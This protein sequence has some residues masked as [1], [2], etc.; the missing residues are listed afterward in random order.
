MPGLKQLQKF[1][2]DVAD[3]GQELSKRAAR[4]EP[5]ATYPLPQGI[6]EA[7]DSDDFISGL[8][9]Q[10]SSG[11]AEAEN[12]DMQA[13]EQDDFVP[14]DN[15][16]PSVSADDFSEPSLNDV[17][18]ADA[19]PPQDAFS[20]D[21]SL[22]FSLPDLDFSDDAVSD[23]SDLFNT[24]TDF[25]TDSNPLDIDSVLADENA[26]QDSIDNSESGESAERDSDVPP[27]TDFQAQSDFPADEASELPPADLQMPDDF[28]LPDDF[29]DNFSAD[30][31]TEPFAPEVP[32]V[33]V[34]AELESLEPEHF[35][36]D[37]NAEILSDAADTI[38]K[39]N[40]SAEDTADGEFAAENSDFETDI[41]AD[42]PA[43][44][45][46]LPDFQEPSADADS[47]FSTPEQFPENIAGNEFSADDF[48]AD[49]GDNL[50]AAALSD[51]FAVPDS[52]SSD[53]PSDIS[54]DA[55]VPP[56][57]DADNGAPLE[58]D[59]LPDFDIDSALAS[60]A[61]TGAAEAPENS[62]AAADADALD[63]NA[64]FLQ[65]LDSIDTTDGLLENSE[66]T[67]DNDLEEDSDFDLSDFQ[68][69][70][71]EPGK[72]SGGGSDFESGSVE[73]RT[74]LTDAEYQTFRKNLSGYPL[75]LR[76]AVEDLIVKNDFTDDAVFSVIEKILKKQT[77]RQ[78]A[79]HIEKYLDIHISV[80]RDF[81]RRTAAQYEEY[82]SSIEYQLKN[83]IVPLFFVSICLL[84]VFSGI[85]YLTN[86]FVYRPLAADK[87]Y[88]QGYEL[89]EDGSYSLAEIKFAQAASMKPKK[90]WFFAFARGYRKKKQ[91][92]HAAA[93]YERTLKWFNQDKRA[94]IEYAEMELTDLCDYERA[95]KILRREVLDY[96]INDK[97]GLLLL[98][99]TCLEWAS[100]KA[101][102]K[103][104]VALEQY[105]KLVQLYG[106][107]DIYMERFLKYYMRT[108]NLREVL[109]LKEYFSGKRIIPDPAVLVELGGYL[110][111]KLSGSLLPSEE[112]LSGNIS[113]VRK[114]LEDGL[115][116]APDLP[117]SQYNL[118]RYFIHSG[119]NETAAYYFDKSLPLF[120][121][122]PVRK[123]QRIYR[124]LD[125]YRQLGEIYLDK[126]EYLRAGK[127]LSDGIELFKFENK[128]SSLLPVENIGK[129][130]A[131]FAD[132]D[133]FIS[134]NMEQAASYYKDAV[135]FGYDTPSVR[136]RLGVIQYGRQN[137]NEALGYFIKAVN[138]EP[139][140]PNALL[141]FANVLS[142]R[143]DAYA[144]EGYYQKLI[145]LLNIERAKYD[146]FIPQVRT[147]QGELVDLYMKASN[148][149]G[150]T[151]ARLAQR[152]GDSRKQAQ[153]M[154]CLSESMRAYDALTRNPETLIRLDGSNLAAQNLKYMTYPG[155]AYEPVIYAEI[156]R[157]LHGE[158][159]LRQSLDA[160]DANQNTN[161]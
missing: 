38:P 74:S 36:A 59:S 35:G 130:Y 83:K 54:A 154:V 76:I 9:H 140:D 5:Q 47:V 124:Q 20:S 137:Y 18:E 6:S 41:A 67:A 109:N 88:K 89:L 159:K 142:F 53:F 22:D 45:F 44:D 79:A 128:H 131:D 95:E 31:E 66:K 119:N 92:E 143:N 156:P 24:D 11:F 116:R 27:E 108:N 157:T 110:V 138:E 113:G 60:D 84:A 23:M 145:D 72:P 94:G 107:S 85:F 99:D 12:T 103:F 30:F 96:H 78:V 102:E 15:E 51:E 104:P 10:D 150:V 13:A 48:S 153:A 71:S 132:I 106:S 77:A 141:A 86:R 80:P 146:V 50:Q 26:A 19:A 158:K 29:S 65:G 16:A 81:E 133:Y 125:A 21:D 155:I 25:G 55:D 147:D 118:G 56:D 115:E 49:A 33:D 134:G 100:E 32:D 8:P 7:D 112:Y 69:N 14:A 1:T 3:L 114:L 87:L 63:D 123:K 90:K 43:S 40:A 127:Y 161:Y 2:E 136:Y 148:N 39:E 151:L 61:Q 93:M 57:S 120:R 75:N 160:L 111:E 135:S 34:L 58:F 126:Q 37:E 105:T 117:E 97:D 139:D 4:G 101:P 98:G 82:K 129:M 121:D 91:Y 17:P 42:F 28:S 46:D 73:H 152:T 70:P 149:L 52:D 122:A 64:D 62:D 144:A 68:F